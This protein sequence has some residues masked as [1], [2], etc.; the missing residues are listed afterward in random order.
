M[1]S[2]LLI[3]L[4]LA[5]SLAFSQRN[6]MIVPYYPLSSACTTY[7]AES[8]WDF[9]GTL[10]DSEGNHNLSGYN[11]ATYTTSN[12]GASG[13]YNGNVNGSNKFF[14]VE[15]INYTETFTISAHILAQS[16]SGARMIYYTDG[17]YIRYDFDAD[18]IEVVTTDGSTPVEAYST[19]SLGYSSGQWEHVM[20]AFN[21]TAGTCTIYYEGSDVTSSG[22]TRTDYDITSQARIGLDGDNNQDFWGYVDDVQLYLGELSS[23]DANTIYTTPGTE[24]T[25]CE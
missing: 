11:G 5:S 18:R 15:E 6:V 16:P 10:N 19:S 17:F 21:R 23:T 22:I 8:R 3:S 2:K 12:G 4:L 7:G 1:R 20:V 9:E 14:L 13:S 25:Y 24:V